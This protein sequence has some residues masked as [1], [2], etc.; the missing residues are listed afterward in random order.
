VAY[1]PHKQPAAAQGIVD[2]LR[3]LQRRS[4]VGAVGF[5]AFST[6]V[7]DCDNLGPCKLHEGPPAPQQGDLDFYNAFIDDISRA[8]AAR[9]P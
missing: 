2:I 5:D 7:I 4:D 1:T 8:Y 6:I 9:F 3:G